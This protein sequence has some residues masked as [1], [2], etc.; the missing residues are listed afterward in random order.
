[1]N[2]MTTLVMTMDIH[3]YGVFIRSLDQL[4]FPWS[5]LCTYSRVTSGWMLVCSL[6]S[7]WSMQLCISFMLRKKYSAFMSNFSMCMCSLVGLILYAIVEFEP[8]N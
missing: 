2:F 5:A 8:K 3:Y 4:W 7:N 6:S 1:M